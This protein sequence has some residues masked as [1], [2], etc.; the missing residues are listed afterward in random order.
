METSKSPNSYDKLVERVKNEEETTATNYEYDDDE[1][2][3]T[4]RYISLLTYEQILLVV[5]QIAF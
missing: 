3:S 4:Y 2:T 1:V 5:T